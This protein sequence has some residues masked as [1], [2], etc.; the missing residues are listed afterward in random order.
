MVGSGFSK[1]AVP[2]GY[3]ATKLPD[4]SEVGDAIYEKLY[5]NK[6][7]EN[8]K[9]VSVPD[10]AFQMESTLSPSSLDKL[11]KNIIPDSQFQPSPLHVKLLE[12][13][14]S[15]VFTTNFDTLLERAS[16]LVNSIKYDVVVNKGDLGSTVRPRIIKLHGSFSS[17][18][19][20]VITEEHYRQYPDVN[21]HFMNTVHQALLENT[22]CLLGFSGHDPNFLQWIG[23]IRDTLGQQYSPKIYNIGLF[24]ISEPE[25]K[26]FEQKNIVIVDLSEWQDLKNDHYEALDRFLD[27][28]L[29]GRK[30]NQVGIPTSQIEASGGV[31]WP[32]GN[33]WKHPK[34]EMS[35]PD[36]LIELVPY[37][38]NERRTYPGWVTVPA[39]VRATFWYDT[40]HW[41]GFLSVE[42]EIPSLLDLEFAFEL[43]WRM[44]KS[45]SPFFENQIQFFESILEKY[46][47]LA[48]EGS[49]VVTINIDS[50]LLSDRDLSTDDVRN[51]VRYLLIRILRFYREEGLLDKWRS[52]FDYI[53][54]IENQLP[55]DLIVQL[56]YESSL[57]A[58]FDLD[59]SKLRE[60]L[61]TWT[62]T[63]ALPLW[64]I[65]KAGLYAEIGD[66]SEASS[67][68]N[69]VLSN[70]RSI[71][72]HQNEQLVYSLASQEAIII[73]LLDILD[74]SKAWDEGSIEEYQESA[75]RTYFDGL[76]SL[77]LYKCDPIAD[78]RY[79]E[80]ALNQPYV[81]RSEISEK[82]E[83]DIG[84]YTRN[85]RMSQPAEILIAFNFLRYCEDTGLPFRVAG[86][87]MSKEAAEG[88]LTRI[89]EYSPFWAIATLFRIGDEKVVDRVFNRSFMSKMASQTADNLAHKCINGLEQTLEGINS[90]DNLR[91]DNIGIALARVIP[92][93]LSRLCLK[94]TMDIKLKL[95][96][97]L[98]NVY[99]SENRKIYVGIRNLTERLF[100]SIPVEQR[101]ELI[102]TLLDFP[103][104]YELTPIEKTEFVNPFRLLE[105]GRDSVAKHR[106]PLIS[107]GK[108]KRHLESAIAGNA[109]AR[110]WSL[111]TLG[112]LYDWGCLDAMQ[113]D[114]YADALWSQ[115]DE[116][117]LPVGTDFRKAYFY[118]LPHPNEIQPF[119]L[120]R[121]YIHTEKLPIQNDTND[122]G[123]QLNGL[124]IPICQDI[125]RTSRFSE[126]TNEDSLAVLDRLSD[127]W[128]ADKSYLRQVENPGPFGTIRGEFEARFT[129]L[130]NVGVEILK[131]E[132]DFEEKKA[133]LHRILEELSANGI[134]ALRLESA[135]IDLFP[136]SK[137]NLYRKIERELASDR[138]DS[139]IDSLRAVL[140]V[141]TRNTTNK[142][143]VEFQK[144]LNT[145]GQI[146][147]FQKGPC[148]PVVFKT[149]TLLVNSHPQTFNGE[150]ERLTLIGLKSTALST[151][152]SVDSQNVSEKLN[153][154]QYAASFAYE[155]YQ[156]Y[157]K[158]G[159]TIPQVV[160]D[161]RSVCASE[162]E[163][164]EIRNQWLG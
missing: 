50:N 141:A 160:L 99:E 61:S 47:P 70:I 27:S 130:V 120:I 110:K 128:D 23:W 88:A 48:D 94:C 4:W 21:A 49:S 102:P 90:G 2:V 77:K 79:F 71:Q 150:F 10:L 134:P 30:E 125:I 14:W 52:L 154:R 44:E 46:M 84:R 157:T 164:A 32:V 112:E 131:P 81:R 40:E 75:K 5:G 18:G 126:W 145:L 68:L 115:V 6:P 53:A 54:K 98:Q 59:F 92:E 147:R 163:F 95:V 7:D 87:G 117:G 69:K 153:I 73:K 35:K 139:V 155:L 64:E 43:S 28:I 45:L 106:K 62:E 136:D 146:V 60:I 85:F 26:A 8:S 16:K 97:F 80:S 19:P 140:I 29:I 91:R 34:S 151:G 133:P 129:C 109:D 111:H 33:D 161:W 15:D 83:Y 114:R 36:Q 74:L 41:C 119:T 51:M 116:F 57:F 66:D 100:N 103:I 39:D 89:L 121:R 25:R 127:W 86:I 9:Y 11:L 31:A 137:K 108:L 96:G 149:I 72:G 113:S 122:T 78:F 142:Y 107:N 12:L 38:R 76:E 158:R 159:S 82:E 156:L 152:I 124:N 144:V 63:E 65:K 17:D 42:D 148:L 118:E 22:L 138:R 1:N 3:P 56:R 162:D 104:L 55:L 143:R 101:L 24:D 132:Y 105:I 67:I 37:W 20:L 13:P 58:L 93:V 135:C 123:I